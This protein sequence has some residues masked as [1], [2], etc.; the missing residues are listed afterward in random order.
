MNAVGSGRKGRLIVFLLLRP[1]PKATGR[2]KAGAHGKDV[3]S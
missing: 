2:R 1:S 3:N